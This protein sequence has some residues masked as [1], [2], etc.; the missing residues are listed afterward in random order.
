[1]SLQR[2]IEKA[3]EKNDPNSIAERIKEVVDVEGSSAFKFIGS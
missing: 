2:K 1:M 3:K